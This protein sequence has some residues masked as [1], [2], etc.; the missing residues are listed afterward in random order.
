VTTLFLF[1]SL[2]LSPAYDESNDDANCVDLIL[3]LAPTPSPVP[4]PT[5]PPSP[6]LLFSYQCLPSPTPYQQ[7]CAA[8]LAPMGCCIANQIAILTS[9][10]Q[11]LAPCTMDYVTR[12]C[13]ALGVDL[14]TFCPNGTLQDL[15]TIQAFIKLTYPAAQ[16]LPKMSSYDGYIYF[17]A[18][19]T[20]LLGLSPLQVAVLSYAYYNGTTSL[21][22]KMAGATSAEFRYQIMISGTDQDSFA[23]T[24]NTMRTSVYPGSIAAGYGKPPTVVTQ[25]VIEKT[26]YYVADPIEIK[27]G[28]AGLGFPWAVAS[29][30][31]LS[32]AIALA[33]FF[34]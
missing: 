27:N 9:I 33:L 23:A 17:R 13:P 10:N 29:T 19:V 16:G 7:L 3:Q 32:G 18:V 1:S 11:T 26:G 4:A 31:V 25:F 2:P 30:S 22:Q 6:D 28:G 21:G 20:K 12:Y 24:L 34:L 15:G 14:T 5:L 8:L